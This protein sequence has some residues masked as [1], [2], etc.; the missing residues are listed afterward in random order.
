[1]ILGG[2]YV[3]RAD[4]IMFEL[5]ENSELKVSQLRN[6]MAMAADIYNDVLEEE[7][8]LSEDICARI[9]YLRVRFVYQSGRIDAVKKFIQKAKI[10]D[11]IKEIQGSRKKYKLF[12]NY[13][14]ALVAYHKYYNENDNS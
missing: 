5:K 11:A 9:Q 3:D 8:Q 2:D 7:E 12:Y 14:E 10:L 13:L 1:M 6:L 4:E